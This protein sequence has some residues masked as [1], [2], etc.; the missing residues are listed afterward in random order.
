MKIL[1]L[2]HNYPF[3]GAGGAETYAMKLHRYL[4]EST[5]YESYVLAVTPFPNNFKPQEDSIFYITNESMQESF[6][7]GEILDFD[8]FTLKAR[9]IPKD[10]HLFLEFYRPDIIHFQ[11]YLYFGVNFINLVRMILPQAKIILTLHE[12][13]AICNNYGQMITTK[14]ELCLQESADACNKCFPT[15]SQD[16]FSNR[17]QIILDNFSNI[18]LFISPSAFLA[19]R[20]VSWGIPTDKIV[21]EKNGFTFSLIPPEIDRPISKANITFGFLGQINPFKGVDVLLRATQILINNYNLDS[22]FTV[23]IYGANLSNQSYTFQNT[24]KY[25]IR[26]CETHIE[27]HEAYHPSEITDILS[28]LDVIVVPSI[29]WENSPLV[30]QEAHHHGVPVVCSNIGGM[31][32]LVRHEVDGWHFRTG[33]HRDLARVMASIIRDSKLIGKYSAH[34]PRAHSMLNHVRT[35]V[36]LYSQ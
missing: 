15:Y 8:H 17:K 22:A 19:A 34:A 13:G 2:V 14:G 12:Y 6:I 32:E 7:K 33:D 31:A 30:I 27:V 3:F 20:Y 29:W 35:L 36:D 24:I 1:Q 4:I 18:D 26:Q 5:N 25:L 28:K 21:V 9:N 10:I 16:M 11:H 23:H